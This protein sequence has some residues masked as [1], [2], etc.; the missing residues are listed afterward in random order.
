V[1][2]DDVPRWSNEEAQV[3]FVAK[4][5]KSTLSILGAQTILGFF[6]SE[7]DAAVDAALHGN[8]KHLATMIRRHPNP[9]LKPNTWELVADLVEGKRTKG[10]VGR[11]RMSEQQRRQSSPVHR[12]AE[13]VFLIRKVLE[14]CYP[15]QSRT[16]IHNRALSL[17]ENLTGVSQDTLK[18]YLDLPKRRRL[19]WRH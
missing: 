18:N 13:S 5:I 12:A 2:D 1:R 16:A 14:R 19:P 8:P 10:K 7:E 17:A 6:L 3:K 9:Q 11:P 4:Q 15:D